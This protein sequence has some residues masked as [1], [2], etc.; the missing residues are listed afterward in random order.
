[1]VISFIT[2]IFTS[3]FPITW[4]ILGQKHKLSQAVFLHK[5]HRNFFVLKITPSLTTNQLFYSALSWKGTTGLTDEFFFPH[6]V[7][8]EIR[9]LLHPFWRNELV[10]GEDK[11]IWKWQL[12]IIWK[13]YHGIF[14][15]YCRKLWN[16]PEWLKFRPFSTWLKI[17]AS[18]LQ[19]FHWYSYCC[20]VKISN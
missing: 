17:K 11:R 15:S 12:C 14:W 16:K 10:H 8:N 18:P 9:V 13:W 6:C 2:I 7:W 20:V 19:N 1:M 4:R 3:F 5:H